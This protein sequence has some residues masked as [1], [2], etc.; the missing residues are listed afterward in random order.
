MAKLSV[1]QSHVT[2]KLD[3]LYIIPDRTYRNLV[4]VNLFTFALEEF[5][6]IIKRIVGFWRGRLSSVDGFFLGGISKLDVQEEPEV[7]SE[8]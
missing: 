2:E 5:Q 3:A 4:S 1:D 7:N 6:N 8:V